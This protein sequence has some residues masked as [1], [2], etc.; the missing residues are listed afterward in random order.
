MSDIDENLLKDIVEAIVFMADKPMDINQIQKFLPQEEG[1]RAADIRSAL[2]KLVEEY[3]NKAV[4]LKETASGFRFQVCEAIAPFVSPMLEEKPQKHSRAFME[5]L[6]L[7]AYR[8]PITRGEIEDIRGVAVSTNIMKNLLDLEW[9]RIVGHKEVPG[10]PALYATTKKFLDHFGLKSID[11]LPP[12][13]ELQNL[14]TID[15]NNSQFAEDE[16]DEI[17]EA[18]EINQ[19]DEAIEVIE[20][21]DE[22][23]QNT[24]EQAIEAIIDDVEMMA[25]ETLPFVDSGLETAE[26]GE[27]ATYEK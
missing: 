5:T 26:S 23:N 10:R 17:N 9:V 3:E 2:D 6:A 13:S 25:Q 11:E 21:M 4:L 27:D 12:L 20:V 14:E 7:T 1:I 24:L 15:L 19:A 22:E 8:Q 16:V 18:E